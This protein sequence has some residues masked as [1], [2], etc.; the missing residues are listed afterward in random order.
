MIVVVDLDGTLCDSAHRD[1]LAQARRWDEFHA[2]LKND[3]PHS[4]VK[5][6]LDVFANLEYEG[7]EI[8][9]LTGRNARYRPATLDWLF[10]NGISFDCLMMRPDDNWSP[11]HELKPQMLQE[12]L[13]M[14]GRDQS[15]VWFILDDREKVVEAWRNLGYNCWQPRPGGY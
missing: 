11:D 5:M 1:H 9:G 7:P 2:K 13:K 6:L 10:N 12:Y 15:D 4:D 8:V 14:T 3:K